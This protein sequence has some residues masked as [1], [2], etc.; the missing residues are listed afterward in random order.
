[1]GERKVAWNG[2][3]SSFHA[4]FLAESIFP[5]FSFRCSHLFFLSP[6]FSTLSWKNPNLLN[7]LQILLLHSLSQAVVIAVVLL[8]W[9]FFFTFSSFCLSFFKATHAALRLTTLHVSFDSSGCS[10]LGFRCCP[11]HRYFI[12]ATISVKVSRLLKLFSSSFAW[13]CLL[14]FFLFISECTVML[15]VYK[16]CVLLVSL[17]VA[18]HF[19]GL[20]VTF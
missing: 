13:I 7:S 20:S 14:S 10:F 17:F 5:S 18:L 12:D 15:S 3:H 8:S 6:F 4:S 9:R 16:F 2:S 11:L 1:M 19:C